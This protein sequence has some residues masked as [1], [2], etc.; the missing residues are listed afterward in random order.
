MLPLNIW[1]PFIFCYINMFWKV[2]EKWPGKVRESQGIWS[3]QAAGNP[4]DVSLITFFRTWCDSEKDTYMEKMNTKHSFYV[5]A[6]YVTWRGRIS[7][8][9]CLFTRFEIK[10][11]VSVQVFHQWSDRWSPD[12][13]HRKT[14]SSH[15]TLETTAYVI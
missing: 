12:C 10:V 13:E 11:F 5:N 4:D 15:T 6:V 8:T 1:R 3:R 2:R 14:W 7:L 9:M